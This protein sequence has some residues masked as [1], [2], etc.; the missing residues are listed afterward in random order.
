M[1]TVKYW[2]L[3]NIVPI[4]FCAAFRVVLK[5]EDLQ[6]QICISLL[7]KPGSYSVGKK[8]LEYG[9]QQSD[10][11]FAL[12]TMCIYQKICQKHLLFQVVLN[13]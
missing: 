8:T 12:A 10:S 7:I 2:S 4:Y 5:K 9:K 1:P 6:V 11:E 13:T 3:I